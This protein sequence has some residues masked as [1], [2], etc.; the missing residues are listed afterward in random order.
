MKRILIVYL[1]FSLIFTTACWD[2]VDIEDRILPYSL[3]IDVSNDDSNKPLLFCFSY[4]NINALGKN[5]TQ[6]EVVYIIDVNAKSIFDATHE[7]TSRERHPIFLKHLN[8]VILSEGVFTDEMYV[9]Q[10]IDG[11]KRDF[12]VNKMMH[13]L[14][15]KSSAHELL[16]KKLESER[17]ETIEGLLVSMLRNEQG[18]NKFTPIR[19]MEFTNAM[20]NKRVVVVPL[21]ATDGDIEIAGGGLFKNYKFIDYIDAETNRNINILNDQAH[22]AELNLDYREINLALKLVNIDSKKRLVDKEELK[23][24]FYIDIDGQIQ[25]YIISDDKD[26]HS[27]EIIEDMEKT[28][29]KHLEA[30]LSSTLEKLQKEYNADVLGILEYL[31]RFH[32]Q[33]YNQVEADW[34]SIFPNINIDV[35]VN[36]SIRRRGL[37]E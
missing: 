19:I 26:I 10:I 11:I 20:D 1:T 9:R 12:I 13:L 32:P 24:E 6:E 3:A 14:I 25:E 35:N 17:Q 36:V 22:A 34:D 27:V 15:T 33:I 30:E 29:N 37:S 21:A 16:E 7:M 23:F 18:S 8:V 28:I 5:P 4:P 2:M 31:N